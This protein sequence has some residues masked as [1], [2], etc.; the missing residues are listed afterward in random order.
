M[1]PHGESS[2]ILS[3]GTGAQFRTLQDP[4]ISVQVNILET[5]ADSGHR[6]I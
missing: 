3:L 4:K 2:I 6:S 1:T 5:K